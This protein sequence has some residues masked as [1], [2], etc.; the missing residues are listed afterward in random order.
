MFERLVKPLIIL[1]VVSTA[2]SLCFCNSFLSYCKYFVVVSIVQIIAY[3]VYAT[4]MQYLFEQA[5]NQRLAEISKQGMTIKCPC[6]KASN[7]FVP[8]DL[9]DVNVYK[10]QDCNK[11]I[12]AA[13]EVKT[14]LVTEPVDVEKNTQLNQIFDQVSK[15]NSNGNTTL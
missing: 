9:N 15:F 1:G 2:F 14:F 8:I 4:I 7:Q 12:A 6:P 3:N 5:Q 10:C 13:P 11:S